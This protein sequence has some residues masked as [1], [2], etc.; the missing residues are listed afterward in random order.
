[1]TLDELVERLA[2]PRTTIWY[3]VAD[4]PIARKPA[5]TWPETARRAGNL[6]MQRKYRA[7]RERG[8]EQGRREFE[9]QAGERGFRDFVCLYIAEGYKRSR[10]EVAVANSDPC[11]IRLA[12]LYMR[13]LAA[14]PVSGAFHYH[15]D[16]DPAA[17]RAFWSAETRIP[18][19][20]IRSH[21][22]SNSGQL[23]TRVWRC[24]YGVFT[25]MAHDTLLRARL[26]AWMDCLAQDWNTL[27]SDRGVAKPGI[28]PL[29]GSGDRRFKS[30]RPD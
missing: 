8:Y 18:A 19:T 12:A 16:Q 17:L 9:T 1:M 14:R 25:V 20:S 15:A 2:L 26:Q 22:K 27:A 7:L 4:I 5:T 3:W 13:R 30:G 10:N 11:V 29:L 24:R 6:A 23:H 28:A 21:E